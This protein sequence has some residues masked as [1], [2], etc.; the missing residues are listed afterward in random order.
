MGTF[1]DL[2]NKQFSR[3][4]VIKRV[5]N[6]RR[7]RIRWLCRCSCGKE[8][9]TTSYLLSSGQA[10][11]CGCLRR[12]RIVNSVATHCKSN[13]K[14]YS[15]WKSIKQRCY[16]KNNKYYHN[17]GGRG[18]E[19][20]DDWKNNFQEFYNWAIENGYDETAI[21]KTCTI[22]RIDNDGIYE[23]DN[24]RWVDMKVQSNNRRKRK[25]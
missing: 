18:I 23:P 15:V 6:D 9:I 20:C 24:C 1:I 2:T 12:E 7:N 13:T 22:D 5:D 3:L 16:N 19:M 14:I 4:T 21:N 8:I 25:V 11:S 10:K 17:Y